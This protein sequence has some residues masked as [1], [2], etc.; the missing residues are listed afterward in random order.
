M[1]GDATLV[2]TENDFVR[3][4]I[5]QREGIR[6]LKVAAMFEDPAALAALLDRVT[7]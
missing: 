6:V 7:P 2:T 1:A 5:A 3:L 4:T